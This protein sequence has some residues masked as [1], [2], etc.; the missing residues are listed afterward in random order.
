MSKSLQP[1]SV[2]GRFRVL[3]L[4]GAGGMG[5]VYLARD[6]SLDRS[7][8]LK[9]LPPDL[10]KNE[11]R[12]RRFVQE[13]KSASSLSHPN[14]VT[15]YEIG[16][17]DVDSTHVHFIAMEL[18]AGSTLKDLIHSKKTDLRTLLRHLAQAAEG[19]A[20]AHAAGIVHR[21]LKPE[22]IMVTR[23]AY[24]K[25][26]DF[27]LAKLVDPHRR[28]G[29]G[30]SRSGDTA[31]AIMQ[32]YSTPGV[33]LGTVGYMS[34]EQAS[35]RVNEIDHRSDIFSFGCI[36]FEAATGQRAFEG[37]DALDSLH[38]IVHAPTPQIK[39][40][41]A[42]APPE[43]QRIVR[44]CLA[45]DPEERYQSIKDV[46]IELKELRREM[47]SSTSAALFMSPERTAEPRVSTTGDRAMSVTDH[48][49]ASTAGSV[50]RST[51]SVEYLV[52]EVRKHKMGA[53]VVVA[54]LAVAV[55]GIGYGIYRL[56]ATR[57]PA[58]SFQTAK[59][60]RLTTTGNASAVAIS[61][62][63]KYVV[64]VQEDGGEQSLWTRQVATQSN[65]QI[66]APAA[67]RYSGLVVSPD[68][69]YLYYTAFSQELAQAVLFQVPTLGGT[70]KKLLENVS[71][72]AVS[73]SPDGK[74]FAFVRPTPREAFAL[75][76]A[77][78]DGTEERSLVQ[79][80]NPPHSIAAPAWSPDGKSI[81]YRV[82]TFESNDSSVFETHIADGVTKSLTAQ[83]WLS[84]GGLTWLANGSGLLMLATSRQQFVNQIWH[85]SYPDGKAHRL[86]NDLN[87]YLGTSLA[88]DS[89]TL[90]VVQSE[91]QAS[92]W[93]APVS[94]SS[95]ARSVTSGSGKADTFLA[96]TPDGRIVYQSN[97][98]GNDDIWITGADGAG[99]KQ[100]TANARINQ[101]PE[102]SPD[103]RYIVFLSYRTGV[104]HLWRMNLDG[105]DQR[106]LAN[107]GSGEASAQFSPDGRWL[108]YRTALG[109]WTVWKRPADG[110][111][112]PVQVT[113]KYSRSPTVSPDGRLIAYF[114]REDNGP[115]RIA[116]A[117]FEGGE[118]LKTFDIPALPNP[119]LRWTPDGRAVAYV[120]NT[121]NGVSN[122]V[123]QPLD[124]RRPVQLTDFKTDR[125]F[126][127]DFSRDG[128]Q[129]ALSRG[130]INN[131]VVLI[132][133][134]K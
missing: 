93:V 90:A 80:Q 57:E 85:L 124:G 65:V 132:S 15:I 36:L 17:A 5:E 114:Y 13:A 11:D 96:W 21:D 87:N 106:Q 115:W 64:H 50:A 47:E 78:A 112:E 84:I 49:A 48:A 101:L 4:L 116:V 109:R 38:K 60:T 52:G 23:D 33:V 95:R 121:R 73:F 122:I 26:L 24:A 54:V 103:G 91:Q 42:D 104:P 133:N 71:S 9:I 3:S 108:V 68:G 105:S 27:G 18:V 74:Q 14:I 32:S 10:L 70:P 62:D 98:S 41:N 130:A 117:P 113:D 92:I 1:G 69:N 6:E 72:I 7:V 53:G 89:N 67:V 66:V 99:A 83:R 29:S 125:I 61:P 97:A 59:V 102:V 129:L 31:T 94:D 46:V 37:K 16:E 131:D 75:M 77:N 81:A 79:Y 22:N 40:F 30:D 56:T 25:V 110:T 128:K 118:P 120:D 44:R 76:I 58:V 86:T 39:D 127:F 19:I 55:A 51:S 34:P 107:G 28:F 2:V 43:L 123:A 45:K 63:G 119:S 12:V 134:F 20:K 35:G 8:A 82:G 100:L 111:G 88:A 126:S